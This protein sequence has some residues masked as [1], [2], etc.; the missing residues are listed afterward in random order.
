MTKFNSGWNPSVK[1]A[2]VLWMAVRGRY[3]HHSVLA[4]LRRNH[5]KWADIEEYRVSLTFK[6]QQAFE[7]MLPPEVVQKIHEDNPVDLR[8]TRWQQL[9]GERYGQVTES[10]DTHRQ[11]RRRS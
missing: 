7:A 2:R 11:S 9:L 6:Q 5:I 3:D 1:F 4:L 8:P 10:L